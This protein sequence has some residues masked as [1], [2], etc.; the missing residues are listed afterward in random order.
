MAYRVVALLPG[1]TIHTV[2]ELCIAPVLAVVFLAIAFRVSVL[3]AIPV[4]GAVLLQWLTGLAAGSEPMLAA[5][6]ELA[7][8]AVFVTALFAAGLVRPPVRV[9]RP[10][11]VLCGLVAFGVIVEAMALAAAVGGRYL[12]AVAFAVAFFAGAT[13]LK[14]VWLLPKL[15]PP[16]VVTEMFSQVPAG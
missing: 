6:H 2:T 12:V 4:V 16:G 7:V 11:L 14:S 9:R 15:G 5:L 1:L 13:Y 10:Y 8:F 3:P